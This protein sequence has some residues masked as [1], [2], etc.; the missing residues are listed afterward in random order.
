MKSDD[1]PPISE[2]KNALAL[3]GE[4]GFKTEVEFDE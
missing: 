2:H 1:V 4:S 3:I